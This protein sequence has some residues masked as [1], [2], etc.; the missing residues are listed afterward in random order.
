MKRPLVS[1]I[2]TTKNE[3][4]VIGRLLKSISQQSYTNIE[5][6]VVDN[7]STD[8]TKKISS[9]Y[10]SEVFDFGPERS[11]QRNFG[12]KKSRGKYV[13]ILDADMELSRDVVKECIE[14]I[15][16]GS[17]IGGVVVPE[18]SISTNFWEQVKA[19][20]R[21][22]YNLEGDSLTE[23]ARF[24]PKETFL[25]AGGYDEAITG[26][27]DWDLPETIKKRGFTIARIKSKIFHYERIPSVLML[28]KKKY[29]YALKSYRYF[30]KQDVSVLS[31][32]AIYFL[33]P[34]FYKNWRLLLR[35][36][37][38]TLG[39]YFMFSLEI[40]AGGLGYITGRL[41]KL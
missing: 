4:A 24:F 28:A 41:K 29:Y 25:E 3:A 11:A 1:V 31:P 40:F 2:V 7:A 34:V 8:N 13:F 12:V 33:R 23:S 32:K 21:S 22:F 27:E 15:E 16:K 39:M 17:K 9:K 6:V 10:T 18:H 5:T 35:S 14:I 36:P 26:P 19:F 37:L 38:L 20:E 30:Q